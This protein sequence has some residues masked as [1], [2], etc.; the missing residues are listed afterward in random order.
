VVVKAEVAGGAHKSD[1]GAV[2][3]D[4]RSPEEFD[5]ALT[6]M[7]GD[8]ERAGLAVSGYLVQ[9][10]ARGGH[11]VIY[12]VSHDRRFGPLLMFGLGGK[13]V[14]VFQ[15]VRFALPPLT[16]TEALEVVRS[17]RGRKLL[18]GVRGEKPIDTDLLA[19]NLLRLAQLV[20]DHPRI[21]ELDINPFLAAPDRAAAKAL[22]VRLRVGDPAEETTP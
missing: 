10:F 21:R 15:D 11:E 4:L 1:L 22:D 17:I 13:Y 19:E 6:R 20:D 7:T 14:E 8:L 12:G 16:R 5:E 18:E 3:V 9:Q 2:A